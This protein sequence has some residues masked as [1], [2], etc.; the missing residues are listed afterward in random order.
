MLSS[1][2]LTFSPADCELLTGGSL[3]IG[4]MIQLPAFVSALN[5]PR[6]LISIFWLL[7]S[8]LTPFVSFMEQTVLV[9]FMAKSLCYRSNI[10]ITQN[11]SFFLCV[12]VNANDEDKSNTV[13]LFSLYLFPLSN[14]GRVL[15]SN[16]YQ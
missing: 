9:W 12:Q 5:V 14:I 13:I 6:S 16:T 4:R 7:W 8:I 2:T 10:E 1:N 3:C 15:P 11:T